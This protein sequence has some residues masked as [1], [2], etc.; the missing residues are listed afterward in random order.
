MNRTVN[1]TLALALAAAALPQ[2]A[3][4]QVVLTPTQD[5][6]YS[7]VG[8]VAFPA[9]ADFNGDGFQDIIVAPDA[10]PY[11]VYVLTNDGAGGFTE[12]ATIASNAGT[13]AFRLITGDVNGDSNQ[14]FIFVTHPVAGLPSPIFLGDGQGGFTR[15]GSA[16]GSTDCKLIDWDQDGDLDFLSTNGGPTVGIYLND[17]SGAFGNPI[18][19]RGTLDVLQSAEVADFDQDGD[20][21]LYVVGGWEVNSQI[22]WMENGEFVDTTDLAADTINY[23]AAIGDLTGNGVMD[24]VSGWGANNG[25]AG[26]GPFYTFTNDGA[27]NFTELPVGLS[28]A[29]EVWSSHLGN[30]DGDDTLDWVVSGN[31]HPAILTGNG[32]GT[33]S[34]NGDISLS[35]F[36]L[37]VTDLNNDGL[38]DVVHTTGNSGTMHILI[39]QT[40]SGSGPSCSTTPGGSTSAAALSLLLGALFV[41]GLRRRVS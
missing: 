25:S 15:S 3:Q 1:T 31:V 23:F 9:A 7:D 16:V 19:Y 20:L 32:D 4:A 2:V 14:D 10:S 26:S 38:D 13:G 28:G 5:F 11:D 21:D 17:G 30:L 6:D 22:W 8:R 27:G 35:R 36:G 29:A 37:I 33:F 41:G 40:A 12:S 18:T 24:I 39:N 34:D